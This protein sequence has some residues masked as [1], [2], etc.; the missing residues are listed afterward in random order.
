MNFM[1]STTSTR[2]FIQPLPKIIKT[3]RSSAF[4][5]H[6]IIEDVD[7]NYIVFW[8]A[9]SQEASAVGNRCFLR[10]LTTRG[11]KAF[12]V[13]IQALKKTG[14]EHLAVQLESHLKTD[15]KQSGH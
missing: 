1:V 5:R 15:Q 3:Y 8:Q 10:I 6:D 2:L 13:F 14:Q 4:P 9:K 12:S 7:T 11:P